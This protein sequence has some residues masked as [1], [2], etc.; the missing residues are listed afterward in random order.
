MVKIRRKQFF[1]SMVL[2][3]LLLITGWFLLPESLDAPGLTG[4]TPTQTENQPDEN[5]PEKTQPAVSTEKAGKYVYTLAPDKAD[6]TDE[7]S[8]KEIESFLCACA[9][10]YIEV[11]DVYKVGAIGKYFVKAQ[12]NLENQKKLVEKQE[13]NKWF[14]DQVTVT[15][16]GALTVLD[17]ETIAGFFKT[18]NQVIGREKFIYTPG[19]EVA[20]IVIELVPPGKFLQFHDYA[21]ETSMLKDNLRIRITTSDQDPKPHIVTYNSGI[22]KVIT[23]SNNIKLTPRELEFRKNNR[24]VK[25]VL[26]SILDPHTR[27]FAFIHELFH[28]IGFTGHSPYYESHLFPLPVRVNKAPPP[29]FAINSPVFTRLAKG[30]VEMLYRPEILPG[31]T[32]KEA[33]EV[34]TQLK[35]IDKTPKNEMI[36]FLIERKNRLE[37]QKKAILEQEEKEY[38][39]RMKKY[40][41]LDQLV[42]KENWYLE[43]LE[44][45]R[46]DF[47]L[48]AQVVQDIREATS[49]MEKLVRIRRELILVENRK[50]RLLEKHGSLN[51]GEKARKARKEL[52]RLEEEIVVLNDLLK[53]EEKITAL[54]PDILAAISSPRQQQVKEK[55]RRILRQLYSIDNELEDLQLGDSRSVGQ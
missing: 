7:Y 25:V 38:N 43:E 3:S 20:N 30:M 53:V 1:L 35:R 15:S 42:M 50:R 39:N 22:G 12:K 31:M 27:Y 45:I 54:E 24:L 47:G 46:N 34:L 28:S 6:K 18:V 26:K 9:P 36:S 55:L 29:V 10:G 48:S 19:L 5:Q 8:R 32:L 51:N 40:I 16:T 11:A 49:K 23:R 37:S 21:G 41:E 44:E 2:I 13:I 17:I 4:G 33:G 14:E 52:K